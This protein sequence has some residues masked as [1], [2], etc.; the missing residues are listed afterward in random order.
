M[1]Q[2]SLLGAASGARTRGQ[3]WTDITGP[4]ANPIALLHSVPLS[5]L[6]TLQSPAGQFAGDD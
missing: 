4:R 3:L 2:P 5:R 6:E 1:N